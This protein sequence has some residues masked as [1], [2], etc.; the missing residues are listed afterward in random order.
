MPSSNTESNK[1]YRYY[2][3]T[4][5]TNLTGGNW[6]DYTNGT[7][8]TIGSPKSGTYYLFVKKVNDNLGNVSTATGST[9]TTITSASVTHH[10]FGLYKLDNTN[11]QIAYSS[12]K[13]EHE[14]T[15]RFKL[16][17]VQKTKI[18][19]V[20][21][22]GNGYNGCNSTKCT[23]SSVSFQGVIYF[24]GI[25]ITEDGTDRQ[26]IWDRYYAV[27]SQDVVETFKSSKALSRVYI[28]PKHSGNSSCYVFK[29][30]VFSLD[31]VSYNLNGRTN[32][33]T[34]DCLSASSISNDTTSSGSTVYS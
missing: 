11:P 32:D 3:S 4:S 16:A 15:V 30:S 18:S 33:G 34:N 12:E 21:T 14:H 8:F 24:N 17:Y 5:S 1:P 25:K 26:V 31:G 9:D 7:E 27:K 22:E 13:V 29:Y 28:L 10:R 19:G 6:V 23:S 20:I 2:L